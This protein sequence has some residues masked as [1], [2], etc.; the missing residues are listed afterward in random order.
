LAVE[1]FLALT[2]KTNSKTMKKYLTYAA[3][4]ALLP[5][6][7]MAGPIPPPSVVPDA[8]ST[9]LLLS[10]GLAGIVGLCKYHKR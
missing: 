3:L 9:L 1:A 6:S 7:V 8:G 5:M 4:M 2:E 10:T